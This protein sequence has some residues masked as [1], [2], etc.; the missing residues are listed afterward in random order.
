METKE[1]GVPNNERVDRGGT[2]QPTVVQ[3]DKCVAAPASVDRFSLAFVDGQSGPIDKRNSTKKKKKKP[4][5][6]EK[7]DFVP[8]E[9][10]GDRKSGVSWLRV[11]IG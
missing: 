7:E 6:V 10:N 11:L 2:A 9:R 3:S 8:S 4:D 1:T 5:Y